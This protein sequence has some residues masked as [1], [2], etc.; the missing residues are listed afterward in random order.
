MRAFELPPCPSA[1]KMGPSGDE[2]IGRL[3][4]GNRSIARDTSRP[5][6]HQHLL[7]AELKTC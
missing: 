5:E 3:V 6:R 1:M 4:E 7:G 2:D